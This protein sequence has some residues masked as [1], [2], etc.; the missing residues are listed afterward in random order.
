[1]KICKYI[2]NCRYVKMFS[3]HINMSKTA[4]L[5]VVAPCS[6]VEDYR[7]FR[8]AGISQPHSS[9]GLIIALMMKVAEPLKRR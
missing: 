5:C 8:G 6:S 4:V 1:M 9:R 2:F 3:Q 7:R